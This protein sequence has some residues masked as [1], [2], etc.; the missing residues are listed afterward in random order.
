VSY[1]G[2]LA[3]AEIDAEAKTVKTKAMSSQAEKTV[4]PKLQPANI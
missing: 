2:N 3:G 1:A 4:I